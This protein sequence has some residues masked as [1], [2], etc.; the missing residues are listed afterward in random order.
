MPQNQKPKK[1]AKEVVKKSKK[2]RPTGYE[3]KVKFDG[4]FEQMIAIS[5]KQAEK[6]S[7]KPKK[8]EKDGKNT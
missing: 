3:E 1:S 8:K 4:T 6:K 5:V 2:P 7:A